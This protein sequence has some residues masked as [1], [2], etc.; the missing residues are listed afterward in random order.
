M[1]NLDEST[2][3]YPPELVS[4]LID[5]VPRLVKSKRDLI[6][7]FRGAGVAERHIASVSAKVFSDKNS[8]GRHDIA[9][10]IIQGMNEDSSDVALRARRELLKRVTEWEDFGSC[11]PNDRDIAYARVAEIR[12]IVG[13][14]DSFTKMKLEAERE[15]QK[16]T[17]AADAKARE[18]RQR[19]I[20]AE[21][22]Q[23]EL[24]ALFSPAMDPWTRGEKFEHVLTGMFR[25]AEILIREPF[26]VRGDKDKRVVEQ[27]D[28]AV[29][30][31]GKTYLVEAK[32]QSESADRQQV[33]YF[34]SKIIMRDAG[35]IFIAFPGFTT[36]AVDCA[37][38]FLTHRTMVLVEVEELVRLL[39][40]RGKLDEFLKRKIDAA[41]IDKNVLS[42]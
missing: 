40:T 39:S 5:A 32:W 16:R 19:E 17:D 6:N 26:K 27:I 2:W 23:S 1:N 21:S 22:L 34:A 13:T 33:G 25:H 11:W 14:K 8:I 12:K 15:R 35:G 24:S 37:R 18:L 20:K 41:V 31:N 36:P 10:E 4:V 30:L 3:H 7:V 9:R 42:K 29:S 28:G 38:E